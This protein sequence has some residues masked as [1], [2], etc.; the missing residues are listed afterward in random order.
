MSKFFDWLKRGILIGD[1]AM[2]TL[3]MQEMKGGLVRKKLT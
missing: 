3:L 1:G 2:G